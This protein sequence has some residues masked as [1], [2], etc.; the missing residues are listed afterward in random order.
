MGMLIYSEQ[1]GQ[2]PPS[3]GEDL[4]WLLG[5]MSRNRKREGGVGERAESNHNVITV[6]FCSSIS[7]LNEYCQ[8]DWNSR[9]PSAQAP[10]TA[11]NRIHSSS[12]C[13]EPALF[14][15]ASI[16]PALCTVYS[17]SYCTNP[18]WKSLFIHLCCLCP[19]FVPYTLEA[20]IVELSSHA[21]IQHLP[22]LILQIS[23]SNVAQ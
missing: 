16:H 13:R 5:M 2:V 10:W 17:A 14:Y 6:Q 3:S 7:H 11:L 1:F 15:P 20:S 12:H 21:L 23:F 4:L 9:P 18:L 8:E 19:A 22:C